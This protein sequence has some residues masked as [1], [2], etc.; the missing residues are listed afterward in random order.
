MDLFAVS[1][2][3]VAAAGDGALPIPLAMVSVGLLVFA[4]HLFAA[5]FQRFRLPDTVW[6][7]GI[8]LV[9][10]PVFGL[11]QPESFGVVGGIFTTIALVV[12]LFEAGLDLSFKHLRESFA[13][14]MRITL[15]C[16]LLT[17][18]VITATVYFFAG[19]EFITALFVG[20]VLAGPSPPVIIPMAKSLNLRERNR[21]LLTLESALGE[22]I[23]LVIALA[24]LRWNRVGG[25]TEA[26]GS[27]LA[28]STETLGSIIAAFIIAVMIGIAGGVIWALMLEKV[29]QLKNTISTTL[30][31]VFIIY[32]LCEML[33]FSGPVA[34]LLF[35]I[36][37]G[38]IR[39]LRNLPMFSE[40]GPWQPTNHSATEVM[41]F[42]EIVFLL[43]TF[44]FVY[45]GLSMSL[46][47][48]T[49]V[50]ALGLIGM[51]LVARLL[52]VKAT[53][54]QEVHIAKEGLF[55]SVMIPKGLAAAVLASLA[56]QPQ[57]GMPGGDE[58]ENLIYAV[59]L[60]SILAS[61]I[62]VFLIDKAHIHRGF[63]WLF[64]NREEEDERPEDSGTPDPSGDPPVAPL[65]EAVPAEP[66]QAAQAEAAGTERGGN[67]EQSARRVKGVVEETL[68]A[69]EQ[70]ERPTAPQ[71]ERAGEPN[72]GPPA[73]NPAPE[74][75]DEDGE[76]EIHRHPDRSLADLTVA[77][78]EP[79]P[80]R[81][82]DP[83]PNHPPELGTGGWDRPKKD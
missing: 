72:G 54:N 77:G 35:G 7:I 51:L 29:R 58:A 22:A 73:E 10:G 80:Q 47:D 61:A 63:V 57:S 75:E 26:A 15:G 24:I 37:I 64:P 14:T 41:F 79:P 16:Y 52:A 19:F 55:L 65:A 82:A 25:D 8:G 43:K 1:M 74:L 28:S 5:I 42:S 12:I 62:L 21:V 60:Y 30:S 66:K 17:T 18:V 53:L 46:T 67:L 11:L 68:E 83:Q 36:T 13:S 27:A 40:E 78:E 33:N 38:N 6:L 23:C 69:N 76:H 34:A 49:S 9:V 32:G 81:K 45:L 50:L 39:M 44:F 70:S 59:I 3:V 48:L 56:A 31:F 20:A 71:S 2:P 4:A